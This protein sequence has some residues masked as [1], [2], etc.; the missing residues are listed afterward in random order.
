MSIFPDTVPQVK[1]E[2]LPPALMK[3]LRVQDFGL[4][5]RVRWHRDL[6][7]REHPARFTAE[8]SVLQVSTAGDDRAGGWGWWWQ[9]REAAATC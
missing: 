9:G 1:T 6:Y 5:S 4:R 3:L 7:D 8:P 2:V